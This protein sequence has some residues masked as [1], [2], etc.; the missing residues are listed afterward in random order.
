[1]DSFSF[2]SLCSVD[3]FFPVWEHCLFCWFICCFCL[4]ILFIS[5]FVF[6]VLSLRDWIILFQ[7]LILK[8]AHFTQ[9][10]QLHNISTCFSTQLKSQT[11]D[12]L[13]PSSCF[14]T[15]SRSR[16]KMQSQRWIQLE[17]L[18]SHAGTPQRPTCFT[19]TFVRHLCS[20]YQVCSRCSVQYSWFEWLQW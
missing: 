8:T 14:S 11:H 15:R 18:R 1:M 19:L 12:Q 6:V 5:R 10:L 13:L 17:E 16:H 4:F 7:A 20:L 9:R 3:Y 2:N